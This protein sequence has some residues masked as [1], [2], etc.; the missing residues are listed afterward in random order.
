[1]ANQGLHL[2]NDASGGRRA[3]GSCLQALRVPHGVVLRSGTPCSI[4]PQRLRD[5]SARLFPLPSL[6][7]RRRRRREPTSRS[8]FGS[9]RGSG[10]RVVVVTARPFPRLPFRR[11]G[12]LGRR[13]GREL[14]RDVFDAGDGSPG[15][16]QLGEFGERLRVRGLVLCG[17]G[18]GDV[19]DGVRG[20]RRWEGLRECGGMRGSEGG[21]GLRLFEVRFGVTEQTGKGKV[22]SRT[23]DRCA[24]RKAKKCTGH[25][26]RGRTLPP[27]L[28]C[29]ES[30]APA[31]LDPRT[32]AGSTP[33]RPVI[34]SGTRSQRCRPDSRRR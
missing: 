20:G 25:T 16:D 4:Q 12:A 13:F 30:L 26:S 15:R 23:S 29:F 18:G 3:R 33:S 34:L 10:N 22:N 8:C 28:R 6:R 31:R 5:F 24:G 2:A 14:V 27:A 21:E 7:C 11:C 1:M 17:R 19:R 32:A 9:R